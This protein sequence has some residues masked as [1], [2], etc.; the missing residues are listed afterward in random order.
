MCGVL[1]TLVCL[2]LAACSSYE[3][4][5]ETLNTRQITSCV[6]GDL[7]LHGGYGVGSA[8]GALRVYTATGGADLSVC[9]RLFRHGEVPS[10]AV[11]SPM[12]PAP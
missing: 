7:A 8:S 6:Q 11:M 10:A 3:R 5:V 1:V 9:L 4:F 2:C 12:P